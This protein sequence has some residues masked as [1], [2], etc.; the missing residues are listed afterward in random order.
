MTLCQ[1][2]LERWLFIALTAPRYR[3]ILKYDH[4]ATSCLNEVT[5]PTFA[6][7]LYKSVL[8][9]KKIFN[10]DVFLFY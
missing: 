2:L 3:R 6:N 4:Q 7:N 10:L 8:I 5:L 1:L 9:E